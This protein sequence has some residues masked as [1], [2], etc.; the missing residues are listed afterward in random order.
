MGYLADESEHDLVCS[1]EGDLTATVERECISPEQVKKQPFEIIKAAN[2][3]ETD[4]D[5][6]SGAGFTA[7]LLSDLAVKEDGSYD[8]DSA[9]PVVIG[10]EWSDRNIYRR[11]RTCLQHCP[12]LRHIPCPG[13]DHAP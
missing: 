10:G 9:E 4:A 1:Y 7:Y 11:E 8:F 12:S 3:G 6:L 5:L 2:N 13:N